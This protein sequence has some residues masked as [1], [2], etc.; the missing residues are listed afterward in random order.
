MLEILYPNLCVICSE[1]DCPSKICADCKKDLPLIST[2]DHCILCKG[3]TDTI[4]QICSACLAH[5]PSW[6]KIACGFKFQK[7]GR[8]LLVR[9]K[10]SGHHYLL[11][12]IVDFMEQAHREQ[13]L[14]KAD[15]IIPV[16]MHP[17][18]K[19]FR[20]W[21]QTELL[22]KEFAK[23]HPESTFIQALKRPRLTRPQASLNRRQRLKSSKHLFSLRN[24]EILKGGTIL[25][26]DDVL[27][28]GATLNACCYA[29]EKAGVH[30]INIL[31]AARG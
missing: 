17:L 15:F 12:L 22:A 18:K 20:G 16:P 30:Q 25:L 31:T 26:I 28:T 3:N 11:P 14:P 24:S 5:P 21:N 1:G 2:Q 10:Y 27:T 13:A 29:L 6:T 9:F 7:V 4:T 19:F 23:R 8:D